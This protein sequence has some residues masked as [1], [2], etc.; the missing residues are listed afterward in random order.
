M[1]VHGMLRGAEE[2]VDMVLRIPLVVPLLLVVTPTTSS[3]VVV[4]VVVVAIIMTL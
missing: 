1:Q 4:V 3:S 2:H